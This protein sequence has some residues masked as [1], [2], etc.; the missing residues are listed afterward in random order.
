MRITGLT[1]RNWRTFKNL[2]VKLG[3]RLIIVGPNASGKSNL[4]DSIRFL[5]DLACPDGG[6]Q[7]AV[8]SRG[9]LSRVRCLFAR[10]NNKGHVEVTVTLG[11]DAD[12]AQWTYSVSFAGEKGG[13]NRPVV[14]SEVVKRGDEV[15]LERPG[16]EDRADPER[17]IQTSLEQISANK[18]FRP[19]ADFLAETRYLH[20]VPQ[21]IRDSTRSGDHRD[22]PFGGDFIARM[23]RV[24][25]KT[26]NSW[27]R[28]ITS[29]L[30]IAVPQFESL[31]VVTDSAGRP[32]LESRYKNWREKGS[33]QDEGD[34]SDGTLR[35][36][37]LL[38]SLVEVGRKSTP[39]L[40]EEPELS[41][42]PGVVGLLPQVLARAQRGSAAQIL[43]TT[44]SPDLLDDE[45]IRPEEVLELEPTT[46]GTVG[47]TLDQIPDALSDFNAG[48]SL[49]DIVRARSAP[50][51]IEELPQ[52]ELA[53]ALK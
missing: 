2:D 17:L 45:G 48:L 41:L 44:H 15:L 51:G 18:E 36:I 46:D 27:L 32:H 28:R 37:G 29:A 50:P 39:I 42:H 22:D 9:G 4:L 1:L 35:L 38:W 12:P 6:L 43:L 30:R 5:R 47:R 24:P 14:A 26:R 13:R 53:R 34:F 49:A 21:I 8:R 16:P 40:L 19:I 31:E 23:N 33:R 7:S 52:I 3:E 11:D 20:L 10:N 25:P